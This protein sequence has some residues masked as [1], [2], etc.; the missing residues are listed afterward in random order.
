MGSQG[1]LRGPILA[2]DG[3][4]VLP[5]QGG[6]VQ[7]LWGVLTLYA[8]MTQASKMLPAVITLPCIFCATASS[9]QLSE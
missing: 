6:L 3:G 2:D 7:L 5:D 1:S 4:Q 9:F 8:E